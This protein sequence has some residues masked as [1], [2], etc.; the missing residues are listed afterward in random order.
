MSLRAITSAANDLSALLEATAPKGLK[1]PRHSRHIAPARKRIKTVIAHYFERQRV[2]MLKEFKPKIDRELKLYPSPIAVEESEAWE[3]EARVPSGE[4]GAGEWTS[5]GGG[6]AAK[7]ELSAETRERV[8]RAKASAV[9]TGQAEQLIADRSEQVLS[10]AI[11]IP[12]TRDN[13]AFDLRNDDVGIEVKT[14][15]NGKNEKITMSKA[16]LGRKVAE[17]RADELKAYTVVVDRRTGGLH[18][19]ATYYYREGLGSFRLGS[20]TK[21]TLSELRGIVRQ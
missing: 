11:G 17:Q 9:R 14:L 18:G 3:D 12:R 10:S 1:H 16:A 15:V 7:E 13:S 5:G 2:A 20:M 21:T 19:Q 8:D 4:P 6:G